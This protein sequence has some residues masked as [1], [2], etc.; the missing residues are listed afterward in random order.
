M[1]TMGYWQFQGSIDCCIP[2]QDARDIT[3][4]WRTVNPAVK[5][6]E[7]AGIGHGQTHE[8]AYR[9]PT[10]FTWLFAQHR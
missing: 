6:T 9:E 10:I 1:P 2:V 5:Y 3:N 8:Y 4:A 7:Y